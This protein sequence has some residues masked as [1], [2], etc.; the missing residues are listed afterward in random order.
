MIMNKKART[1]SEQGAIL[2]KIHIPDTSSF[3]VCSAH[4]IPV[5][6]IKIQLRNTKKISSIY[7]V[8]Y[9][10]RNALR[11]RRKNINIE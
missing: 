9:L 8:Y 5:F 3:E 1:A 2:N 4:Q 11:L 10:N 6:L 7:T